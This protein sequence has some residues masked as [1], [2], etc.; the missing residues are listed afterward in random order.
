MSATKKTNAYI[1]LLIHTFFRPPYCLDCKDSLRILSELLQDI[2]DNWLH[3]KMQ[4]RQR[5]CSLLAK[6][7]HEASNLQQK[8]D[9]IEPL[10]KTMVLAC[11]KAAGKSQHFINI[12]MAFLIVVDDRSRKI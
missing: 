8:R 9:Y 11:G 1:F 3:I 10:M 5:V 7:E 4:M 6:V 2:F 12:V